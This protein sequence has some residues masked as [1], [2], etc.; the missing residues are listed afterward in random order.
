MKNES[1][2]GSASI[3][4]RLRARYR[5]GADWTEVANTEPALPEGVGFT[6]E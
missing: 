5:R 3:H 6:D 2:A 1:V 4:H